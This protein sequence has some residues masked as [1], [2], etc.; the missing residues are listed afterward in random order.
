M[1]DMHRED[2][3][4]FILKQQ[5]VILIKNLVDKFRD[6]LNSHDAKSFAFLLVE[7]ENG[8]IWLDKRQWEEKKLMICTSVLLPMYLEPKLAIKSQSPSMTLDEVVS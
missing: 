7:E 5:N 1:H 3:N 6:A 8:Q 2:N 4:S